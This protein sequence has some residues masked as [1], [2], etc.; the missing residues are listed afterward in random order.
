M[1]IITI[2]ADGSCLENPGP[3]G[4]A[5]ILF[6]DKDGVRFTKK[7]YGNHPEQ[8]TNNRMELTA[9]LAGLEKVKRPSE[10]SLRIFSDSKWALNAVNG[11]WKIKKNLDL[12]NEA[13]RMVSEFINVEY[14][15]VKGHNKDKYNEECDKL[16]LSSALVKEGF[17]KVETFKEN[18]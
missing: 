1:P 15:W 14:F 4:Y 6:M 3:G 12:V 10:H 7:V 9:I 16:A 5:A 13:R 17:F 8:T 2:Y 18:I 11:A